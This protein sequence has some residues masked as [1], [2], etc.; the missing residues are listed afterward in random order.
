MKNVMR[1]V[2]VKNND[3][4]TPIIL[5]SF[6]GHLEVVKYLYK[7]EE[8]RIEE[9]DSSRIIQTKPASKECKVEWADEKE[10]NEFNNELESMTNAFLE[11]RACVK[12]SNAAAIIKKFVNVTHT[13]ELI[14]SR[15]FIA[16]FDAINVNTIMTHKQSVHLLLFR[17]LFA[18]QRYS[19]IEQQER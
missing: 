19:L 3:G 17:Y 9:S 12:R 8:I 15:N 11:I 18:G 1:N 2:E 7:R 14:D 16:A 6:N 4:W 5:V 10:A 13:S